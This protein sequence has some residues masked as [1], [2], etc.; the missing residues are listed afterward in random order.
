MMNDMDNPPLKEG[1]EVDIKIEFTGSKGDGIGKVE[2]YTVIVPNTQV[3]DELT[4]SVT[5][6]LPNYC[7]AERVE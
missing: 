7:F 2:G 4:V 3:G 5:R 6:A 1:D